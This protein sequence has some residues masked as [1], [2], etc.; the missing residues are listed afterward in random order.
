MGKYISADYSKSIKEISGQELA[1]RI[2][3]LKC[4]LAL[5]VKE[6]GADKVRKALEDV[7]N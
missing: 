7:I 3:G 1:W 5:F 4:T 6:Y 2:G